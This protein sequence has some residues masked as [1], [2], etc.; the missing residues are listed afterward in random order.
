MMT[1]GTESI[2]P[3]MKAWTYWETG[4]YE[5]DIREVVHRHGIRALVVSIIGGIAIAGWRIKNRQAKF[6]D[7][8]QG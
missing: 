1:G 8:A 2:D 4:I 6:T 5:F 7:K 3:Y